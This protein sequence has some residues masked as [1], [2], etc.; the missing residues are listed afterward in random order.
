[1]E[2]REYESPKITV[3]SLE[4]DASL[5]DNPGG[6]ALPGIGNTGIGGGSTSNGIS[7]EPL[8][9]KGML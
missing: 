8:D 2:N 5:M 7:N 4:P 1:M 3:I 6:G 9:S